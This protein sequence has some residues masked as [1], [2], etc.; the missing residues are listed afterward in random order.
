MNTPSNAAAIT[1]DVSDELL[2]DAEA[3]SLPAAQ[4]APVRN[5]A[6]SLLLGASLVLIAFNLRPVFSSASALLPEIRSE[7][8]LG[9]LGASLLTTLPV[10]CL[11][12]FSPL[13]PRL[14]QRI[15]T[16]RT[17]LGV[18]LL[19]A[20]GTALRGLSSVPLL[21]IGTAL[22]GACIAVG[23]VLLPGLVKRDFPTR[24][25]LMTG[26]YT[27][28]LCAGAASA[29][30]LTLPIEHA[31][32][33]SLDG[34]LAAWALPA[35]A[36]GLIWL[37]QVLRGGAGA[38]RNGFRVD[39]LWRDRLAWQVTLFM[40]L[41]SA[42]AYCVF[43]WLVPILRERGLDGVTAGAIVSLSVMV[44]AA[45]CLVVPHIAV[46]GRDQRL[47]NAGLCGVAVSALL[48]LLF[49]PLS[50]V[51]LWAVLQ[52]IGQG[53]LIAAAMTTIVLRS[54]DPDVAAHLSG[55]A[56]C[57]GY[58]LAAIGPLIVGL[59]RGWTGS[60][61]WCAVLFVALGLGAAINGWR[62]G[63]A[64]EVNVHAVEKV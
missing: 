60:F 1:L 19:L 16:E 64:L 58:L 23:N 43:G 50:S 13:A 11:G 28:A 14:A 41:Q 40:G 27:M 24:A 63:R 32:G 62:A 2:I 61:S 56:Q 59:I 42:L 36:I 44:Q 33:G 30:G 12:V 5:G 53:G 37:P 49:A 6:A 48:G 8:G 39:G 10:V 47:I 31:L 25:A 21:F 26:F 18:L 38:R 45:S 3:G 15:G 7:L 22:A 51:W 4:A 54:R 55:M 17:L 20:L 46:R 35:L 9:A 29:A 34:A 57:V 52:G